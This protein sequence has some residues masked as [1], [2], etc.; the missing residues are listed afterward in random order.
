MALTK[1]VTRMFPTENTIGIHLVLTDSERPDLGEGAQEV[2]NETFTANIP[3]DAD[4]S[5]DVQIDLGHQAQKAI[6]DYKKLATY[7][8]KPAYQTKVTQI[9]NNLTL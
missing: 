6:N 1:T 5:D 4:M 7:Y 2:V 8:A 3:S 9:D